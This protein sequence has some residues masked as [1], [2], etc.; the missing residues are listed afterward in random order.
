MIIIIKKNN[1]NDN[2]NNDDDENVWKMVTITIQKIR[3]YDIQ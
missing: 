1:K 2:D 3:N